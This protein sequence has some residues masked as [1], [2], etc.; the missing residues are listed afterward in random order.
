LQQAAAYTV[1]DLIAGREWSIPILGKA[2]YESL[3][4]SA[5]DLR[6]N[7]E[8]YLQI[9]GIFLSINFLASL[10]EE[11]GWRAFAVPRLQEKYSSLRSGLIVG[12]IWSAWH[13]PYFF[14][15]GAAHYGMPFLWFLLTLTSCSI[16]MVWFMNRTNQSFL[17]PILFH[18]SFN[19]SA[20]FLP[21]QI[22]WQTGNYVAFWLTCIFSILGTMIVLFSEGPQLGHSVLESSH[23]RTPDT[24]TI[25][26]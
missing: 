11:G 7:P 19:L 6:L 13:L 24:M 26:P 12:V 25:K 16:L 17:M 20:Q 8:N 21:P 22:A 3:R 23:S 5:T 15:K 2:G 4:G 18:C 1:S 10:L 14:T 9:F